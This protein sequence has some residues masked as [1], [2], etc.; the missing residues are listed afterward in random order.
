[1]KLRSH[2]LGVFLT[3]SLLLSA[4]SD[5]Q[6]GQLTADVAPTPRKTAVWLTGEGID[7]ETADKLAAV[8]VDQLVVRRGAILHSGGAPVVQLLPSPPVEGPIP[9]A[10]ELNIPQPVSKENVDAADA[11]WAALE[12]DFGNRLPS[13]IILDFPELGAGT[14]KF[15]SRLAA[16]SGL[17][18]IPILRVSQIETEIG[19]AVAKAAHRCIVPLFGPQNDDL[20]GLD[21]LET[22]PVSVRLAA[23]GDLGVR[24]RVGVSLRPRTEPA[25][26]DWAE[27]IDALTDEAA[28]EIKRVSTLDRSFLTNRPLTWGGRSLV[29]VRPSRWPGWMPPDL[30]CI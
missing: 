1:M 16:Q 13:E 4:C 19:Q 2:R 12:T 15:V 9:T 22:Q 21:D 8:G 5:T 23:L 27:D 10:V 20:R 18:V 6:V 24:V 11:V 25:V 29:S 28:A 14:G 17:A 26:D 7:A 3:G 30:A